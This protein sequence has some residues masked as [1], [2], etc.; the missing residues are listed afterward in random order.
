MFP[1]ES[2]HKVK[3]NHP[4]LCTVHLCD[5]SFSRTWNY[6]TSFIPYSKKVKSW[7]I[8]VLIGV[9]PVFAAGTPS[10]YFLID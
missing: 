2:V 3:N 1:G 9:C 4:A 8:S 7:G 5:G 6:F 10:L